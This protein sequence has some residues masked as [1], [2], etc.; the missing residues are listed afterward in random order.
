MAKKA[1]FG[2]IDIQSNYNGTPQFLATV[3][4]VVVDDTGALLQNTSSAYKSDYSTPFSYGDSSL[5]VG[6][7]L[8]TLVRTDYGD[9]NIKGRFMNDLSGVLNLL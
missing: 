8:L 2:P 9:N 4:T 3:H 5:A 1:F 7:A 6:A